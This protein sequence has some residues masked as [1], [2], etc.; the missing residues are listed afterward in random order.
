MANEKV[1]AFRNDPI[2]VD[3]D[4]E[5]YELR[6]DLNA[7]C[8]LEKIY[9]SVD[10]VLQMILGTSSAPDL[11]QVTYCD[12]PC[13]ASDIKIAGT[14][15]EVYIEKLN[16]VKQAKHSDT[17]NLLWAGIIHKFAN[18]DGQ[19]EITGYSISKAKVAHGVTFQNI[20]AVNAK[21]VTAILRDLIPVQDAEE[22]NVEAPE[23]ATEEPKKPLLQVNQ[24]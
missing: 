14:P 22:G 5:Q 18:Y 19:G 2:M 21:I 12:A 11:K 20:R 13:L 4:G 8:E 7:F 3:I 23:Q 24:A 1:R 10:D 9:D 17:R 15:L 6:Y 16:Q